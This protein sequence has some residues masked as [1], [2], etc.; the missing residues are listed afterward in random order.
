[1][2]P[3]KRWFMVDS[4]F[5][6]VKYS[7]GVKDV[8]SYRY[9]PKM[10]MG[11]TKCLDYVANLQ[12][13]I[14]S[15]T[16]SYLLVAKILLSFLESATQFHISKYHHNVI[17]LKSKLIVL[18][19][20]FRHINPIFRTFESEIKDENK[21][22]IG[23]HRFQLDSEL[24]TEESDTNMGF[25]KNNKSQTI[26]SA[27]WYCLRHQISHRRLRTILFFWLPKYLHHYQQQKIQI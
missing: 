26:F 5:R 25:S 19:H 24:L 6:L 18:L 3:R 27:F 13:Q 14:S 2:S 11:T 10:C 15:W 22:L 12:M 21:S 1:M 23:K 4:L 16:M 8:F 9:H 17:K 20:T 7:F